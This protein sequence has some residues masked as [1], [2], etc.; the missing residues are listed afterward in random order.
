MVN[1]MTRSVGSM[2]PSNMPP[3]S[4][5]VQLVSNY[6]AL[7][8]KDSFVVHQYSVEFSPRPDG[9]RVREINV[10]ELM[11][12]AKND[13]RIVD[14]NKPFE[15]VYNG[16]AILYMTTPLKQQQYHN[17]RRN[18]VTTIKFA[19]KWTMRDQPIESSHA[20]SLVVSQPM[21][22]R[23]LTR[24]GRNFFDLRNTFRLD[25]APLQMASGLLCTVHPGVNRRLF[26]TVDVLFKPIQDSTV[27][28]MIHGYLRDGMQRS[29][30]EKQ[31]VGKIAAR[32]YANHR[33]FEISGIDW[34]GSPAE[35]FTLSDGTRVSIADYMQRQYNVRVNDMRQ[36]LLI[37]RRQEKM[38]PELCRLTGLTEQMN[39]NNALKKQV[40][41]F[42]NM[43]PDHRAKQILHSINETF[44]VDNNQIASMSNWGVSMDREKKMVK[45]AGHKLPSQTIKYGRNGEARVSE[46]TWS[47]AGKTPLRPVDINNWVLFYPQSIERKVEKFVQRLQQATRTLGFTLAEPYYSPIRGWRD[48]D[49]LTAFDEDIR[50]DDQIVMFIKKEKEERQYGL[51]KD[52]LHHQYGIQ[53][54]AVVESTMFKAERDLTVA[55]NIVNQ[56]MEK[57]GGAPHTVDGLRRSLSPS[58]KQLTM[59]VGIDVHHSGELGSQR[60]TG[61]VVGFSASLD[62]DVTKFY[63]DQRVQTPGQE[64]IANLRPCFAGALEAFKK[65]NNGK[66]PTQLIV[67]RDGVGEG[68]I[69]AVKEREVEQLRAVI[70]QA[71]ATRMKITMLLV[72]KRISTRL[73][74]PDPRAP[75]S[76]ENPDPGTVV[77]GTIVPPAGAHGLHEFFMVSAVATNKR[78]ASI[79]TRYKTII[80]ECNLSSEDLQ[81]LVWRLCHMYYNLSRTIKVPSLCM[82]AHRVALLHGLMNKAVGPHGRRY[83][84]MRDEELRHMNNTLYFL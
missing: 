75:N 3:Q 20:L 80:N 68:Q 8:V 61:S 51:L 19:R 76:F 6:F 70:G 78:A 43:S 25:G 79:P 37:T 49:Y 41:T 81:L 73:F 44:N 4:N 55:T 64:I 27:L 46:G 42:V 2:Q 77:A 16:D 71:K 9:P 12:A 74:Q 24:I 56:M 14:Q 62:A 50:D 30:I 5:P 13:E 10:R 39:A 29:E 17:K 66:L 59:I 65:E 48:N 22:A 15:W 40:S 1:V 57:L 36:P 58:S 69:E 32:N 35:E 63:T 60:Q 47:P 34:N 45:F 84:A 28:D 53:A 23:E 38:L 83:D 26:L 82:H 18:T 52:R 7:N 67:L 11:Q 31:L 72:I 21:R 33:T 54:Q